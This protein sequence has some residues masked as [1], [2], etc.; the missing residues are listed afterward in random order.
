MNDICMACGKPIYL[1]NYDKARGVVGLTMAW[2]HFSPWVRHRPI[3]ESEYG[4]DCLLASPEH[5]AEVAAKA[6]RDAADPWQD[7]LG[8]TP[9]FA[10]GVADWLHERADRIEREAG[11]SGADA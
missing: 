10:P 2:K 11:E 6:L 8:D 4:D 5:D 1:F 7:T 9:L 3:P